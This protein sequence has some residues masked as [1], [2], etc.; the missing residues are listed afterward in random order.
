M[1]AVPLSRSMG[2]V[3]VLMGGAVMLGWWLQLAPLVRVLPDY[4]PMV[5]NTAL[6]FALAGGALLSGV[7]WRASAATIVGCLLCLI[8]ALCLAEN[9]T[10]TDLG[11]DWPSLHAWLRGAGTPRGRMPS[12]TALA[13][14]MSGIAMVIAARARARWTAAAVFALA[15]AVGL[16]GVLGLAGYFVGAQ[17]LFPRYG[18]AGVS[19]HGAAGCMVL[20]A[21]VWSFAK[22]LDPDRK[23]LFEQ[24][25]DRIT[26]LGATV[27]AATAL[28]AGLG[29]FALVQ[30]RVQTLVR[31]DLLASL[32]RRADIFH[33]MIRLGEGG[34]RIAATRPAVLRNLRVIHSG[35]DDGSNIANVNA[36]VDSFLKEGFRAIAYHDVDGKLV[37]G[38]GEFARQPEISVI[39]DTPDRG[40]LLWDGGFV[41]RHRL[42]MRD[43]AGLAGELRV[44]QPLSVLTRLA[45]LPEGS[46]KTWDMGVC[47][48][49]GSQLQCF[50]QRLN[51]KVFFTPLVNDAGDPLPMTRALRGG[52]GTIITRDYRAQNVVA[53]YG[54]LGKLGL[55]MVMKV[56][57]VEIF[58]PIREQLEL[59]A[60]LLVVLVAAGT[61]LLRSQVRPLATGLVQ[62]GAL[63]RARTAELQAANAELE[64]FSYSVSH[65]LRAPL[66][67]INGFSDLLNE[68]WGSRLDE[69]GRR[70]LSIISD[71]VRQ[72]G[73]L[74]DDLLEFSK[75][76]RV[77]MHFAQVSM[78]DV[79]EEAARKL[80]EAHQDRNIEWQIQPLAQVRGDRSLL[81]QVWT[82]LLANAVKYT[83]GRQIA[84]IEVGCSRKG[85]E[86]EF[87][88]RDNGAGFDM[89]YAGKLFGVFQ[90][91]HR[92]EEFEGTG[93][94]LAN[95]LRVVT[96]HGRK[97]RA[98][99]KVNEGAAFYFTLPAGAVDEPWRS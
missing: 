78:S 77:E 89:K 65:D 14:L 55:G 93:V 26:F 69:T 50:P 79:V 32:A 41:L 61:L 48:E 3:L 31:D 99:G 60:A 28:G 82:N 73:K 18:F 25:D 51:P 56:D 22:Q 8:A 27:L 37:A 16:I 1:K 33:D 83:R 53:A 58:R 54:P 36:V 35:R 11:V 85:T 17:L 70:Y 24:P 38:R 6:S 21:A 81:E 12:A 5:F 95:V 15:L 96:R 45:Q 62:A 29:T 59:A 88:V 72:M 68:E 80:K 97:I 40:E 19:V 30:G 76:G 42:P 34:A 84:R 92:A 52:T 49:R 43:A 63:A 7:R 87:F 64:S 2:G 67:H 20:A 66:R 98:E 74:I 13:L 4:P 23:A 57:A 9:F 10:Q 47:A 94:G 44:E 86:L 75:I 90:R 71:S 39:L 46:G 91:L